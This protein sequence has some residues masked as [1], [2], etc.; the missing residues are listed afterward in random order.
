MRRLLVGLALDYVEGKV[1]ENP[2]KW[3]KLKYKLMLWN[4]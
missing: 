3:H 4:Y 2:V 1:K